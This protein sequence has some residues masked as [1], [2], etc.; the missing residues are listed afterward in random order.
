[1]ANLAAAIQ[2]HH[3]RLL[4]VQTA[5]GANIGAAWDRLANVDERSAEQFTK[6]AAAISTASIATTTALSSSLYT[7]LAPDTEGEPPPVVIRKG[8]DPA[9]LYQ[10]PIITAR[11]VLSAGGVWVAAMAAGRARAVSTARTDVMLANR[12]AAEAEGSVRPQVSGYSRLLNPG[13]CAYCASLGDE[14]YG[15][16]D[17]VPL[18]NNCV[19]GNTEV[20]G[21]E[22]REVSRR[23]YAGEVIVLRTAAGH[24]LTITPNHPVLTPHGW[25]GAGDL[26]EGMDVL[27]R[28][29]GDRIRRGVPHERDVP[30]RIEDRFRAGLVSVLACMP[31]ATE[32]FHGD[33]GDGQVDVVP[34]HRHLG[35]GLFAKLDQPAEQLNLTFG[36]L[37]R[38]SLTSHGRTFEDAL[39]LGSASHR[40]MSGG[41]LG[42]ALVTGH[43]CRHQSIGSAS[44][45][46]LD[47]G[48]KE[49]A[50]DSGTRHADRLADGQLGF[51]AEVAPDRIVDLRRVGGLH[52]VFNLHTGNGWYWANSIAVHNCGCSVTPIIGGSD[53][54]KSLNRGLL[55]SLASLSAVALAARGF[56]SAGGD[57]ISPEDVSPSLTAVHEHGEMGAVIRPAG[58]HFSSDLADD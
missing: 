37:A 35:H 13:A 57:P 54:A 18:H 24:E 9:E 30:A 2:A 46:W 19:I 45:T 31:F 15:S 17:D 1:M 6:T 39:V 11:T 34:A 36:G 53:P 38:A 5:A 40:R 48:A 42:S 10:R 49:S 22:L 26:R 7:V 16:A 47:A 12:A 51:A 21:L 44:T 25:V 32:H 14:T 50:P 23:R 20:D 56:V 58:E 8:L 3:R 33:V 43:R 4:A 52:Y 55:S 27:S 28:S 41:G 29:A